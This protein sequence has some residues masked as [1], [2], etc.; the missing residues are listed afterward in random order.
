[1]APAVAT[2]PRKRATWSAEPRARSAGTNWLMVGRSGP[3]ARAR[4]SSSTTTASSTGP[5][6]RPPAA[7]GTVERGPAELDHLLPQPVR[8]NRLAR[9]ARLDELPHEGRWALRREHRAH[10][11]AQLFLVGGEVQLHARRQYLTPM[12][13]RSADGRCV[14]S[15]LVELAGEGGAVDLLPGGEGERLDDRDPLGELVRREPV[16]GEGAQVVERRRTRT[17]RGGPRPRH[18]SRPSPGPGAAPSRP[19]RPRRERTAPPRPRPG[20]RC[21]RH[22]RTS[23]CCAR[24]AGGD[25]GRRPNRDRRCARSRSAVNAARGRLRVAPVPAHHGGRPEADPTDLTGGHRDVGFV[26]HRE[27]DRRVRTADTDD[28]VLLGSSNAVP[29]PMPASVHEYRVA[30]AAPKRARASSASPGVTG[31]PPTTR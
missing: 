25:P 30:S 18:R 4:P 24:P 11:V 26:E 20:T 31:P 13:R 21:T 28:R 15:G 2:G 19:R 10:G 22:G 17:R 9:D 6:P 3:G 29:S 8:G 27:L 12:S 23:P 1:M 7:S 16:A 5:R 14:R